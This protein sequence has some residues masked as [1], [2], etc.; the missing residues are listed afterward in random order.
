MLRVPGLALS[1][2]KLLREDELVTGGTPWDA[3]FFGKVPDYCKCRGKILKG[4]LY[5]PA[6]VEMSL[7]VVVEEICQ[8][9][10]AGDAGEAP[11]MPQAARPCLLR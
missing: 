3:H 4:I 7:R 10:I 1:L 8:G 6:A 5:P 2:D 11:S 9:D